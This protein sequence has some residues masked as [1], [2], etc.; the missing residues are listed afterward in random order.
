[1]TRATGWITRA[2]RFAFGRTMMP[3]TNLPVAVVM[4]M[5]GEWANR[6]PMIE[7]SL[8][9]KI[10]VDLLVNESVSTETMTRNHPP[11]RTKSDEIGSV[12]RVV[13]S[14]ARTVARNVDERC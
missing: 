8:L 5:K 13:Y 11:K 7:S 1:M 9:E 14:K 4:V 12:E 10:S 3:T 6:N 2:A